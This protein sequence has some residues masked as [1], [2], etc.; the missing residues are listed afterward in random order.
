MDT[1]KLTMGWAMI[2]VSGRIPK[3]TAKLTRGVIKRGGHKLAPKT[4]AIACI[5][6]QEGMQKLVTE[7]KAL[8]TKETSFHAVYVTRAQWERSYRV[9]A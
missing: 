3:E 1:E 9:E 7:F 6:G 5:R 8:G 2:I 4:F